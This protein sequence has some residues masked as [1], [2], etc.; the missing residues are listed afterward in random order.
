LLARYYLRGRILDIK[1]NSSNIHW[2][3]KVRVQQHGTMDEPKDAS[4][5]GL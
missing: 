1:R 3:E 2:I 5:A 4:I